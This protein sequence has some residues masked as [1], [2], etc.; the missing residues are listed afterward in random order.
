MAE[1]P[2]QQLNM[3]GPYD[4]TVNIPQPPANNFLQSL[5]G[6]QQMKGLQ[7]QGLLAEQQLAAQRQ[8]AQFAQEKQPYELA[9]MRA[10]E[11]SALASAA[12]SYAS[13]AE[14]GV[15]KK[16]SEENLTAIQEKNKL[17]SLYQN[18][19]TE[20]ANSPTSWTQDDL[21]SLKMLATGVDPQAVAGIEKFGKDEPTSVPLLTEA[22]SYVAFAA[23][24]G[25][26]QLIVPKLEQ[27]V[28]AVEDKLK[29]NP[30]D[31]VA[32]IQLSALKQNLETA[33]T[34]PDAA[35]VE[36]LVWLSS[37][38]NTAFD[39]FTKAVKVP[40]EVEEAQAKAK[41]ATAEVPKPGQVNLSVQQQ[42][43]INALTRQA[44]NT[45]NEIEG[46]N[47]QLD[48]LVNFAKEKPTE[49]SKGSA[50]AFENWVS[51]QTGD[52]SQLQN[53]RSG[54]QPFATKEWIAK[55]Q[56]L[57]G[58]LSNEEG[59]RLDKGA[60]EVMTAGPAE[61]LSWGRLA[62]KINMINADMNDLDA[63]WQQNVGTLQSKAGN[64]FEVSG[65]TVSPGDSY[66]KIRTK[67]MS[68][69]KKKDQE[70]MAQDAKK[71]S[72]INKA[73]TQS[74]TPM[75]VGDF[76]PPQIG[77]TGKPDRESILNKYR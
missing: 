7:Q 9:Q 3:P 52:T 57:K 43:D 75:V 31:S 69:Y 67:I 45:R 26:P 22:S 39:N 16:I 30:N 72:E 20:M 54:L 5:I 36:A 18:K 50:A 37:F 34:D 61:L 55:A 6:I 76:V 63:A 73:R 65:I 25:K 42:G 4:Y 14:S 28:S 51:K 27:Y 35:G 46:L 32:K 68:D 1:E 44:A 48:L 15:R 11:K 59:K 21:K 77:T 40:S 66:S 53:I 58:G 17:A 71:V 33:K 47:N 23:N 70:Q 74:I 13:A 49:F 2:Q 41:K 60:P 29:A 62:T 8:Q 24:S 38:N 56:P 19:V 10:A 12:S 64:S